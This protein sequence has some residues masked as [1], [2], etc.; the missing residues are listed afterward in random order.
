MKRFKFLVPVLAV[1]AF[2]LVT[3][4][5]SSPQSAPQI[6]LAPVYQAGSPV[7]VNVIHGSDC[8]EGT[9]KSPG[10]PGGIT[11]SRVGHD[12]RG[13]VDSSGAQTATPTQ[14]TTTETTVPVDT[15]G[16][17]VKE[18]VKAVTGGSVSPEPASG[19][20]PGAK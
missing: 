7:V 4:C 19:P 1:C 9:A 2:L 3:G 8:P 10:K 5:A 12:A 17:A 11:I 6:P 20:P 16:G 14:E 15:G 18:A 13:N